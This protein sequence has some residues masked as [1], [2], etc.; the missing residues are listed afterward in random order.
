MPLISTDAFVWGI[1][2]LFLIGTLAEAY[3]SW[4]TVSRTLIAVAW[5]LFGVFWGTMAPYFLFEHRSFIEGGLAILALPAF[6]YTGYLLYNG[7]SSLFM[8]SRGVAIMGLIY[9]PVTTLPGVH[10]W[11]IEATTVNTELAMSLLGY[12]PTVETG[13]GGLEGY[14]NAFV[15]PTD[16]TQIIF[17]IVLACTGLGSIAIFSG[18]IGA[19]REP[20]TTKLRAFAIVVPTIY[21]LN[22]VRTTFIAI[23]F[24]HQKFHIAPDLIMG[25][26][27]LD[28]PY[29]VSFIIA[30]RILS[31]SF[32]L[33]TLIALGFVTIRLVP[34]LVLVAEDLLFI[35][36]RNEYD[37]ANEFG[38]TSRDNSPENVASDTNSD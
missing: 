12:T 7:R 35:L 1:I 10:Q 18:L 36:T 23:T 2:G 6:V 21:A 17:S 29:S 11:L 20:L 32:A 25:L 33:V 5:G 24:G 16:D 14:R 4:D 9:L 19:A 30:D 34:S 31:Q 13:G 15:F 26:F 28:S 3:T 37:L 22:I 8:L 27:G 38:Y